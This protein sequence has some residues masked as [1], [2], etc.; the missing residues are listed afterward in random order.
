MEHAV[1]DEISMVPMQR[2]MK[3]RNKHRMNVAQMKGLV[4]FEIVS[5]LCCYFNN[6]CSVCYS[7]FIFYTIIN[8]PTMILNQL[9][10]TC[11]STSFIKEILGHV[12]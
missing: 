4:K 3:M 11:T 2:T 1:V 9:P 8:I 12:H 7:R 5:N 6:K 10:Y